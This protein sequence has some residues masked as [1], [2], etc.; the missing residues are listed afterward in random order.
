MNNERKTIYADTYS[1]GSKHRP[2]E[3]F[4]QLVGG[5]WKGQPS[6]AKKRCEDIEAQIVGVIREYQ[7]L[8]PNKI[9][10][11]LLDSLIA[12]TKDPVI[13]SRIIHSGYPPGYFPTHIS[14]G[15]VV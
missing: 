1:I 11:E 8:M 15:C 7:S 3:N 13:V 4:P 6:E 5:D 12:K 2:K 9:N 10:K 14:R